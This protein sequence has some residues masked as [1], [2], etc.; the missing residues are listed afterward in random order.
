MQQVAHELTQSLDGLTS[1]DAANM[2][3]ELPS[4]HKWHLDVGE[5]CFHDILRDV[6]QGSTSEIVEACSKA[7]IDVAVNPLD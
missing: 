6:V 3:H 2:L 4:F 7:L 5:V 1:I